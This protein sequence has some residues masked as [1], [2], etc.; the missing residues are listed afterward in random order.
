MS[1]KYGFPVKT[2]EEAK[3]EIRQILIARAKI[4][5]PISYSELANQLTTIEI[6]PH[7]YALHEILGEISIAEDN[8]GRGLLS[9]LVVHKDGNRMPGQ[10]C[11]DLAQNRGRDTSNKLK[12]WLK[13]L[14][15]V[16]SHWK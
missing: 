11:F 14:E 5:N 2:W 15:L 9:I 10:G 8:A 6:E 1:D 13:E 12:F 16:H 3:E 7:A 4:R